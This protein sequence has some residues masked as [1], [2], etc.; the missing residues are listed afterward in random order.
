M[1]DQDRSFQ[2]R[3]SDFADGERKRAEFLP[4]GQDRD[5]A[6]Q[7]IRQAEAASNLDEWANSPRSQQKPVIS[8]EGVGPQI[9]SE[10]ITL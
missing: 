6:L 2:E 5:L 8:G 7:K 1:S 3:L 9:G 4:P 10:I